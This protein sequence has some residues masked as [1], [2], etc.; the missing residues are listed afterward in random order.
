MVSHTPPRIPLAHL[1]TPLQKLER[2]SERLGCNIWV[3][4][5]DLTGSAE[6][7][8]K[9]RK[10]EYTL[11]RAKQLGADTIITC[12]GVQSNHCRATALLAAKL[13]FKCRLLLRGRQADQ[14][15]GNLLLDYTAGAEVHFYDPAYFV[16]NLQTIAATHAADIEAQGG[17]AYFIPI[18]ASDGVGVWGYINAAAELKADMQASAISKADIVCATGSAGTQAGLSVGVAMHEM[19]ATVYGVAVCDDEAYFS[20]KVSEDLAHW[21]ELYGIENYSDAELSI[22]TLDG[23]VGPGYSKAG[24]EIF[25]L[26]TRVA[27]EE[28]L[29]LDPVYTGKAFYGMCDQIQNGCLGQNTDVIFVHTG[30]VFGLF[31]QAEQLQRVA[32]GS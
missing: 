13:G 27:R 24:D 14:M 11:A 23:Y 2:T 12:G 25:A 19:A 32:T 3:K 17:S 8:N 21:R 16:A 26:I 28:G 1:P 30:G 18:G 15:Q 20:A 22:N 5:D 10:L 4:R 6:G 29:V 31:S 7:G 9:I